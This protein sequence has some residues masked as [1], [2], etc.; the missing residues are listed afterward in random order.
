MKG[1]ADWVKDVFPDIKLPTPFNVG[2]VQSCLQ[3]WNSKSLTYPCLPGDMSE[4]K[5]REWLNNIAHNLS[6][7]HEIMDDTLDQS[8][9]AF[10]SRTAVKAPSEAFM[11]CKLYI[12]V[13]DQETQ[14]DA[15]KSQEEHLHWCRIYC[16]VEVT[17]KKS[18]VKDLPCQIPQKAVC[19]FNMQPQRK[20]VC[21]LAILGKSTKLE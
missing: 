8:D 13:I 11:L 20:F 12:S 16:I 6:V 18:S 15:T 2:A 21:G 7:A 19:I 1:T 14:H 9:R 17:S 3:L 5:V 10:D 4:P